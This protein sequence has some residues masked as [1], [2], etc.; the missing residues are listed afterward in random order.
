MPPNTADL[1]KPENIVRE[2]FDANHEIKDQFQRDFSESILSFAE[3]L[4]PSFAR[5]PTLDKLGVDERRG[6]V[7]NFVFGVLDDLLVSTK[8]FVSGHVIPSGNVMRQAIEG[9]C[10]ALLCSSESPLVIDR[11]WHKKKLVSE[12]RVTYWKAARDEDERVYSHKALSQL[13]FNKTELGVSADAITRL[14]QARE[15][16][17]KFSHPNLLG[18]AF[19]M[20]FGRKGMI[21]VGGAYDESK[22]DAYLYELNERIGLARI[23]PE[24]MDTLVQRLALPKP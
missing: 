6:M 4:A 2:V 16:C 1:S 5:F 15:H 22:K 20:E 7:I 23:I 17:H 19:R 14:R 21:F 11:H 24:V 18:S 10:C 3:A 12:T 13:A 8:L 9:L